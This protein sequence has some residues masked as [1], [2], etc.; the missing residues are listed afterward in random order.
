MAYH[1]EPYNPQHA[2][3][4]NISKLIFFLLYV[5]SIFLFIFL[6][7]SPL[8]CSSHMFLHSNSIQLLSF[9]SCYFHFRIEESEMIMSVFLI[10]QQDHVTWEE[11][12]IF[13]L[14]FVL[15]LGSLLVLMIASASNL[16]INS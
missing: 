3:Y 7:L 9:G 5:S 10:I 16:S 15:L 12:F 13:V 4:M 1:F 6:F 14:F 8:I 11:S 2:P